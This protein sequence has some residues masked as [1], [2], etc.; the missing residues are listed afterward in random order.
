LYL[1]EKYNILFLHSYQGD[2]LEGQKGEKK[3]LLLSGRIVA[4][5][6]SPLIIVLPGRGKTA[7]VLFI[8][9]RRVTR[10]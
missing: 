3:Y 9:Q 4:K 6:F 1:I 5:L 10:C 7:R 8:I 2:N